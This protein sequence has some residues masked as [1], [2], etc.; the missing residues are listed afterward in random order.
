MVGTE[1][2]STAEREKDKEVMARYQDAI[3]MQI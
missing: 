2:R 1:A 3:V